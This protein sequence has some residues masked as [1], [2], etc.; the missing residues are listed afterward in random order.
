MRH[1]DGCGN[2]MSTGS[3]GDAFNDGQGGVYAVWL[4]SNAI[5][6]YWWAR[7]NIPEDITAGEPNPSNWGTPASRFTGGRNC[8]ISNYF[9]DQTIVGGPQ[10]NQIAYELTF[11]F[12]LLTPPFAAKTLTSRPGTTLARPTLALVPAMSTLQITQ[13]TLQ[14]PTGSST[15]LSFTSKG[16]LIRDLYYEHQAGGFAG[17]L[18][19]F[20]PLDVVF[21]SI[22]TQQ[23]YMVNR[24]TEDLE[25]PSCIAHSELLLNG[26]YCANHDSLKWPCLPNWP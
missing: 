17:T 5:N 22:N 1:S 2:T 13:K 21:V 25:T 11:Y 6:I 15:L 18:R 14:A 26:R 9:K 20:L 10:V 4:D 8:D 12:R 23:R 7:E 3:Y 16:V 24:S 19:Y